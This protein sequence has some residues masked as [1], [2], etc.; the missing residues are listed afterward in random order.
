MATAEEAVRTYLTALRE[1]E[2]LKDDEAI[3]EMTSQLEQASDVIS[4][5]GLQ[6]ELAQLQAPSLESVEDEFVVHAKS[7]ADQAG[8]GTH[9]FQAEGVESAVLRRAGFD[10][11]KSRG[12]K[13]TSG[14]R[15][16]G[17]RVTTEEVI[18]AMPSS[19]FTV[20]QLKEAS[21]ASPAVVRKAIKQE[22]GKGRL[23]DT[24]TDP[25]HSGP[26]RAPTLYR[27]A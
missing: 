21:G 8:I 11:A 5:L 2:S 23:V 24:G 19:A 4:R 26:G 3:A 16:G 18:S 1:P 9:A 25:D 22:E 7:W 12:S 27:K 10:V 17:S 13:R 6:E 14:R 15:S 20:K